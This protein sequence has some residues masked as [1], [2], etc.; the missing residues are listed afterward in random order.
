MYLQ[1]SYTYLSLINITQ[2]S[3][4]ITSAHLL[5]FLIKLDLIQRATDLTIEFNDTVGSAG[6]YAT[7]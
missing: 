2:R 4:D 6:T 1:S 3:F 7:F 5:N